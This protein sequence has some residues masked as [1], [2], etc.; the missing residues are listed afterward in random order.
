MLNDMNPWDY[1]PHCVDQHDDTTSVLEVL[2]LVFRYFNTKSVFS[3]GA[4]SFILFG[5]QKS[6]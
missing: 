6:V 2:V 1:F 3:R 5:S 4:F